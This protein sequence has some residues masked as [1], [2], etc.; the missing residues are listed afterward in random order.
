M[1]VTKRMAAT[2]F[3]VFALAFCGVVDRRKSSPTRKQR[4][5]RS[6]PPKI[7][8]TGRAAASFCNFLRRLAVI[9]MCNRAA[10]RVAEFVVFEAGDDRV[11]A[12]ED[13]RRA[14]T[15]CVILSKSVRL[16]GCARREIG[17]RIDHH[18][19]QD[20]VRRM[21]DVRGA[22]KSLKMKTGVL[23]LRSQVA[24]LRIAM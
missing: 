21:P 11:F 15:C 10:G 14:V 3:S 24:Q 8:G 6:D 7:S 16:E 4:R 19:R 12:I 9:A 20:R 22:T 1:N 17:L 18:L 2:F 13:A 23:Y 5:Q